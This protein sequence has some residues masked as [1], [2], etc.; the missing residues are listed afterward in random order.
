MGLKD[1]FHPTDNHAPPQKPTTAAMAPQRSKLSSHSLFSSMKLHPIQSPVP[2]T[3][4]NVELSS[5]STP[6]S[7]LNQKS[8]NT[9]LSGRS[10]PY[11]DFRNSPAPQLMDIKADVMANWLHQRQQE[12]MWASNGWDEGVILKKARDDYV[13]CPTYLLQQR[14]G[15]FDSVKS[16]N[17]KVC[18]LINLILRTVADGHSV[19]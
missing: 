18:I 16:L 5:V 6:R 14:D 17:V 8:S 9:S 3:P 1:Y 2:I 19:L 15:F 10:Y 4:N 7:S 13:S 11:G 12:R